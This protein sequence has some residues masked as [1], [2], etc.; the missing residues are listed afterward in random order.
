[1]RIDVHRPFRAFADAEQLRRQL[2]A[3]FSTPARGVD[4]FSGLAWA[5][6]AAFPHLDVKVTEAGWTLTG[7][8]AGFT[9]EDLKI[10]VEEGA[11]RLRGERST[12]P[13][14]GWR[15]V[16]QERHA[17]SFDRSIRL[18]GDV[19]PNGIRAELRDGVLT[20]T[21]PRVAKPEPVSVPVHVA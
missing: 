8:L 17:W 16:R 6:R 13:A 21:V 12:A 20:L 4:P 7:D 3:V 10:S 14:E 11:L 19:D 5:A 1:M 18:G 2:D 15:A 9:P